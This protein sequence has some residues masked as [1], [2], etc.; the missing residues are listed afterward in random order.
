ML[1]NRERLLIY[2]TLI[3][4]ISHSSLPISSRLVMYKAYDILKPL[5]PNLN[6]RHISGMLAAVKSSS[7]YDIHVI[8]PRNSV[9]ITK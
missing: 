4:I 2:D 8:S 7:D 3:R 9:I 1:I 5:I 6:I